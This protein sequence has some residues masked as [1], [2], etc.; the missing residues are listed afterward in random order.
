MEKVK[1][2]VAKA[3]CGVVLLL[4]AVVAITGIFELF[5]KIAE[6]PLL[7]AGYI[8]ASAI[9]AAL[10]VLALKFVANDEK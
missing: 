7:Q 3:Y 8:V 1:K 10:F 4:I 6:K 2:F 5:V 9:L